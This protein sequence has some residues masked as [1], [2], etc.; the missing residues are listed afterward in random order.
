MNLVA[1]RIKNFRSIIDSDWTPFSQDGIT[2][3]VGQNESGKS[4]ILDALHFA[5]SDQ[6]P[7]DDDFRIGCSLPE[8]FL[9]FSYKAPDL[10]KILRQQ[11]PEY[12]EHQ[13]DLAMTHLSKSSTMEIAISWVRNEKSSGATLEH[14]AK[15]L[16]NE[17]QELLAASEVANLAFPTNAESTDKPSAAQEDQESSD[18]DDNEPLVLAQPGL[19]ADDVADQLWRMLP[20]GVLFNDATGQLP[21]FVDIDAKG[22]PTGPGSI[23]ARNFLKIAGVNLEELLKG[24]RRAR[25]NTLNR[26]NGK[27]SADFNS[28]WSQTIGKTG[29]LS[30]KCDIDHY[31]AKVPDKVGKAHLVF[32]IC[33]G[34][35][36]LYP[37][38]RSQ[39]V[40]WFVSFYLQL[41]A[42][43]I[44]KAKRVFL[45]D[46]PGANLH[47]KA[48]GDVLKL[49]NDLA[50]DLSTVIYST[51]SP[52]LLEY[53][54]LY[55]VHAV[56]RNSDEEDSPTSIIDAHRLGTAS[57]DTLSPVLS[58]MGVDLSHHQVIRKENNVLLEEMSGY[59]YLSSFWKLLDEK[60]AAYFIAAT[61]VNK[62]EALANMFIGWGLEFIVA[63]DDDKQGREAYKS[64]KRELFGDDDAIA[65]AKLIKLPDCPGIEDAFSW[66]DF[67]KHVLNDVDAVQ[68]GSNVDYIKA[69]SRSKPVLAFQFAQKVSAGV[70]NRSDFDQVT[71]QKICKI[72]NEISSRLN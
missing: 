68:N 50:K 12:P 66:D 61:G 65:K 2:V 60:K 5:L 57:S 11:L 58:A 52:Q 1:F 24:D 18:E 63:V 69:T 59:Y 44:S 54:K 15:F 49:I 9:R 53:S 21:N 22:S 42:S 30:L 34:N 3:F 43:E 6:I 27:V 38:Q 29:R 37:R 7:T 14:V 32:W 40:R 39:G 25:E 62:I 64:M 48:Q 23:A 51:H 45:L 56:Q 71:T 70:V 10:T 8:V 47:A 67:K 16:T 20:L 36:Q 41:K 55:R 28:F 72:V 46:E 33:D 31:D 13:V 4:S 35:T 17:L 19:T 26:A